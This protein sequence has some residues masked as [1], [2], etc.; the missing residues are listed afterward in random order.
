MSTVPDL[1][2]SYFTLAGDVYP[3]GPSEISPFPFRD[4]VEAAA[5]AGWKGMGLIY[6]DI[7]HTAAQ[8]GLRDMRAILDDNGMDWV[9]LEF[10]TD[11]FRDDER[12][13]PSDRFRHDIFAMAEA[14]RARNVKVAPGLGRNIA[15]PTAEEMRPDIDR[16][17]EAF[18]GVCQDAGAHGLNIAMEIMPFSNVATLE[19]GRRIV[20]TAN[21]PNGGLLLDIWHLARGHQDFAWIRDI[22]AGFMHSI[23]LDDAPAVMTAPTLWEDTI[24][25][26]LL[27]GEGNLSVREFI[28][29]VRATGFDSAW[30]VE[31]LN[32]AF[33]KLPLE[34]MARSAFDATVSQFNM[35]VSH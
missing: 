28:D 18:I 2:A 22:P 34:E 23:E 6:V 32:R 19:T 33:R 8:I 20:E 21:Q 27:P 11:W 10:L 29:A 5:R 24:H 17:T 7:Q 31:I 13:G 12:R 30:G 25:E 15:A 3:F 4:R 14:L 1:I 16:M 35:G 26:R 9:E